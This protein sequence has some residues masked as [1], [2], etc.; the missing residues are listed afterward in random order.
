[1]SGKDD[2]GKEGRG[3]P[4]NWFAD[5]FG[6]LYPVVYAHRTAEAAAP[7]AA[8]ARTVTGLSASDCALDLCCGAGRHMV[9]LAGCAGFMAGL[10]YSRELLRLARGTMGPGAVLVRGDMRRIP[11]PPVFDVVFNFFT[12]FGYF[13]DAGNRR[14]LGEIGRVL[15]PGGRLFMDYMNAERELPRLQPRTERMNGPWRILERRWH[16]AEA[17]RVN[18]TVEVERDGQFAGRFTESVRCY[19]L[20]EMTGM[21]A[22]AGMVVEKVFG[23]CDGGGFG[24]DAP[25]MLLLCRR[26]K[27]E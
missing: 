21:L 13:D 19:N 27:A 17:G 3:A 22:G 24:P 15:R 8:F 10:D 5:A 2:T 11:F 4:E 9:H 20:G 23:A 18:K 26:I 6:V 14:A 12:S 16:D 7:E 25:R 1:M